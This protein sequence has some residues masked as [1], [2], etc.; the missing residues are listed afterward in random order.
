MTLFLVR[1]AQAGMNA[2]ATITLKSSF[3]FSIGGL[4]FSGLT[5]VKWISNTLTIGAK[6][7]KSPKDKIAET[8]SFLKMHH[9]ILVQ[10]LATGTGIVFDLI[11]EGLN[12]DA[13][14]LKTLKSNLEGSPEQERM[15]ASL[16]GDIDIRQTIEFS[17][18]FSGWIASSLGPERFELARES[19]NEG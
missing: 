16:N 15:L 18:N 14:E 13:S 17:R 1:P 8:Q 3:V 2:D 11:G 12:L 9:A 6:K 4:G 19:L 5:T 10:N 7:V